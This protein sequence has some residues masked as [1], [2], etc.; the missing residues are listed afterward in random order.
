MFCTSSTIHIVHLVTISLPCNVH[1]NSPRTRFS[2]TLSVIQWMTWCTGGTLRS[3]V[4]CLACRCC[5]CC[6]WQRLAWS[7]WSL[8]YC[9]P[10]SVSPSLSAST[11]LSCRLCRSPATDIPSSK[12][13][14][15]SIQCAV[16]KL[17]VM[18]IFEKITLSSWIFWWDLLTVFLL[19]LLSS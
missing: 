18:Y 9:W 16:N 12:S 5:C 14:V 4:W 11:N 1:R 3:Q 7:V 17:T 6:L 19:N 10:C 13:L 15:F 8:T 2:L